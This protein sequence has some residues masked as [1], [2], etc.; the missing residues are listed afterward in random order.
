MTSQASIRRRV[1]RASGGGRP[2]AGSGRRWRRSAT[3]VF[4]AVACGVAGAPGVIGASPAQ[5]VAADPCPPVFP[6][7]ELTAGSVGSGL[8]VERGTVADAFTATYLGV[9]DDGIAPG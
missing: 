6:T 3:A 4:A 1:I 9:I 7:A 8:T 2:G 5:A